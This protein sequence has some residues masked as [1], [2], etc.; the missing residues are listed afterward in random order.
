MNEIPLFPQIYCRQVG[1]G[2]RQEPS[3]AAVPLRAV[4]RRT[5][6]G[7]SG[8]GQIECRR[9]QAFEIP[10]SITLPVRRLVGAQPT[11]TTSAQFVEVEDAWANDQER[12][13]WEFP[14]PPVS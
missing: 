12:R 8:G 6:L 3:A 4:G 9:W 2:S 11:A 13:G 5:E 10:P 7:Q 1:E 14:P